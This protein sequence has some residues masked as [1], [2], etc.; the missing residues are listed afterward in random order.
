MFKDKATKTAIYTGI[1][2]SAIF[3]L[4]F[5]PILE[6]LSKAT[7]SVASNSFKGFLNS[8][9]QSCAIGFN[10]SFSFHTE[11]V[12]F[13]LFLGI[14]VGAIMIFS[15]NLR[16]KL[17]PEIDDKQIKVSSKTMS[18]LSL[19]LLLFSILGIT[20]SLV[21]SF[22]E[23]MIISVHQQQMAI[24]APYIDEQS[25]E[26]LRSEWAQMQTKADFDNFND[27]ISKIA[28]DNKIKIPSNDF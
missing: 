11:T 14:G 24:I 23:H 7:Y 19:I 3:L 1:I 2:S 18:R 17:N 20:F 5:Q 21:S 25:E 9:I 12:L 13:S 27:K 28:K 26:E 15:R 10:E 6:N 22:M 8:V 4:F 16:R